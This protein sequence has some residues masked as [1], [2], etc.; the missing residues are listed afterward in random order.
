MK[1]LSTVQEYV[2]K[3]V[4]ANVPAEERR[5]EEFEINTDSL[6]ANFVTCLIIK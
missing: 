4:L 1:T 2:E 5:T 6:L 3:D